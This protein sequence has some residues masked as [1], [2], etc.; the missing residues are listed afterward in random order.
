[1]ETIEEAANNYADKHGFRVPY[2]VSGRE[3][4]NDDYYDK[5]DV[6]ASKEGFLAG[7]Q[8][9]QRWIPVDE[10]LPKYFGETFS[11]I[12]KD[13]WNQPTV[14]TVEEQSDINDILDHFTHWS[15]INY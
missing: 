7:V 14:V 10:E 1:M 13:K 12:V 4:V 15:P 6:K 2:N 3:I 9:A 5:V 8:F 11:I